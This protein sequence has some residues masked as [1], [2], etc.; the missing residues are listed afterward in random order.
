MINGKLL[1]ELFV[2]YTED[3]KNELQQQINVMMEFITDNAIMYSKSSEYSQAVD[4]I[5]QLVLAGKFLK[6]EK[7]DETL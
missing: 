6:R 7:E 3:E 5:L 2:H 4:G 1:E